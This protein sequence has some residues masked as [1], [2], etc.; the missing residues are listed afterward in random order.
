MKK[1]VL[2]SLLVVFG[3][4]FSLQGLDTAQATIFLDD[5]RL[6]ISGY[7]K[8]QVYIRRNY[9]KEENDF[10]SSKLN[11]ARTSFLVEALYKWK[12][13][14]D[15]A[16]NLFLGV[17]WWYEAMAKI[18]DEFR[19][20]VPHRVR[21]EYS[22]P[23]QDDFISEAYIDIIKGPWQF[24]IGKQI[25]VWGET[26]LQ[27]TADVINP[28]DLRYGSPGTENWED[29]K[30]GLYMIRGFYQTELPGSLNFE[31]IFN[32]GHFEAQ[33]LPYEGTLRGPHPGATSFN[34]GKIFGITHWQ[35]EKARKD[36]PGW[37][38][39]NWEF[40]FK[41]RGYTWDIDWAIFY[42]NTLNDAPTAN[43]SRL[44]EYTLIYVRNGLGS[45]VFNEN[46]HPNPDSY[47]KRVFNFKR[48]E[49]IGGTAQTIIDKLHGSEWRLEWFYEIGNHW[50]KGTNG[51]RDETYAEVQRDIAGFGLTYADR[52]LI[53]YFGRRWFDSKKLTWSFTVFYEKVIN[54]DGDLILDSGRGHRPG[55]SHAT[56][57]TW[58]FQQF[59]LKSK[60]MFMFT[61][62][63][64]PIGKYFLSPI[65]SYAPGAHWRFEAAFAIYGSSASR[66][67]GLYDKDGVLIRA[68]YEF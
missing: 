43:A 35:F 44:N 18:D 39:S 2:F 61:G 22:M 9:P 28:L 55:D 8:E 24:K 40:G 10:H 34:P 4:V 62:S 60:L 66:N 63:Y 7:F 29:I 53:P 38:L 11:F 5:G 21:H 65:I 27:R 64:N 46:R 19:R 48:Y 15:Y 1:K 45:M 12:Q 23:R 41:V 57:F 25:V 14:D 33:R 67:K 17:H 52:G 54:H 68:R 37:A 6:E 42:F 26:N 56:V 32:P 30:L 13:E 16:V 36:E 20:G 3:I 51:E 47:R 58:S 59:A 49:V 31:F 50:N